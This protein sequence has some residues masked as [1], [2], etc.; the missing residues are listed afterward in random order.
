MNRIKRIF[1]TFILALLPLVSSGQAKVY[2]MKV[3]LA[4]FPV[5]TTKIVLNGDMKFNE[6]LRNAAIHFWRISPYELCTG[7]E[8]E[9]LKN[10]N[11]LYFLRPVEKDDCLFL[12]L[13]KGGK[14]KAIDKL[15]E[16]FVIIDLP[17]GDQYEHFG[18]FIDI[19]Q[20]FVAA[21]M[22]SDRVAYSGLK[23]R[24][25]AGAAYLK[26]LMKSNPER[27]G[28]ADVGRYSIMYDKDTHEL[29]YFRK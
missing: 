17:A 23:Y 1:V 28:K 22:E 15:K 18:A 27:V 24:N 25:G 4:D 3:K 19:L 21:A 8:Y 6:A 26:K 20:D 10:D 9:T 29:C 12:E 5:K 16:S 7:A 13:S 2:T 11:T 14:S